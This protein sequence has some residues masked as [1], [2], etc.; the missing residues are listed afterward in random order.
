MSVSVIP[1]FLTTQECKDISNYLDG[2]TKANQQP[3]YLVALGFPTSNEASAVSMDNP[4]LELSDDEVHNH[5]AM[6]VTQSILDLKH[7]ME[8]EFDEKLALIN[9]NY[10]QMLEGASNPLHADRTHLDGTPYHDGE[11]L[12]F[13]ALIYFND[14]GKDYTGG[15]IEFPLEGMTIRPETGT[16]IFFRGDVQHQHEVK[17]VLSGVRK[18]MVLFFGKHGNT[19]DRMFFNDEH[20]G[21][22]VWVS[23]RDDAGDM[24]Y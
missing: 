13:S 18:N 1:N 22:D 4:I 10:V 3:H 7:K 2:I 21:V 5:I 8:E 19:S 20:S 15:E 6:L 16:A 12:E 24:V 11:E 17:T 14:C 23:I 9:C